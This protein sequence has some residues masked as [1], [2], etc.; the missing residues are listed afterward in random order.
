[1]KNKKII[2]LVENINDLV[3]IKTLG[4]NSKLIQSVKLN[5][6][7]EYIIIGY[8]GKYYRINEFLCSAIHARYVDQQIYGVPLYKVVTEDYLENIYWSSVD[9]VQSYLQNSISSTELLNKLT[10]CAKKYIQTLHPTVRATVVDLIAKHTGDARLVLGEVLDGYE[11]YLIVTRTGVKKAT[12]FKIKYY[13]KIT[14]R[15]TFVVSTKTSFIIDMRSRA[16][17]QAINPGIFISTPTDFNS[18]LAALP[19]ETAKIFVY[20]GLHNNNIIFPGEVTESYIAPDIPGFRMTL[21]DKKGNS[22]KTQKV[23]KYL[24]QH[25][26]LSSTLNELLTVM[27]E[28]SVAFIDLKGEVKLTILKT[29]FA[30]LGYE[31]EDPVV[32]LD[33]ILKNNLPHKSN[34]FPVFVH[35]TSITDSVADKILEAKNMYNQPPLFIIFRYNYMLNNYRHIVSLPAVKIRSLPYLKFSKFLYAAAQGKEFKDIVGYVIRQD[36]L[37]EILKD[38]IRNRRRFWYSR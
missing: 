25:K 27:R 38:E 36:N 20:P 2:F 21:N 19:K 1:M 18:V 11:G 6:S 7:Y 24:R 3:A 23:V 12:N 22:Q 5:P 35:I 28:N 26:T 8:G 4:Y 29:L 13:A 37:R 15:L 9:Y 16:A 33:D 34:F 14:D 31:F 17:T 32:S 10:A 30:M